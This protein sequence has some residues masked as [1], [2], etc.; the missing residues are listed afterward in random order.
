MSRFPCFTF[1]LGSFNNYVDQIWPNFD[2]LPPW[3]ENCGHFTYTVQGQAFLSYGLGY[4]LWLKDEGMY[5][6]SGWKHY[7]RGRKLWGEL[8]FP[9]EKRLF[10]SIEG[11]KN[12][13]CKGNKCSSQSFFAPAI[14]FFSL[15][16]TFSWGFILW[17]TYHKPLHFDGFCFILLLQILHNL[18]VDRPAPRNAVGW[19]R[20]LG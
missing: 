5:V 2:H 12:S 19:S 17:P 3:V 7:A 9:E 10:F 4:S 6:P 1:S 18:L 11:R 14:T 15:K 8:L 20:G 13:F 16:D